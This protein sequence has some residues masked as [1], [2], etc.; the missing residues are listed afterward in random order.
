MTS[1]GNTRPGTGLVVAGSRPQRCTIWVMPS[2]FAPQP[3]LQRP[4]PPVAVLDGVLERVA[5]CNP[6]SQ[7]SEYRPSSSPDHQRLDDA[8]AQPPLHRHHPREETRRPGR[9]PPRAGRRRPHPR[10]RPPPHRPHPPPPDNRITP[11]RAR[12][13]AESREIPRFL[14]LIRAAWNHFDTPA[15]NAHGLSNG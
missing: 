6:R 10:R 12:Q 14:P 15:A 7:G 5:F 9:L 2:S 1:D 11:D 13:S 8:P 3:P 4:Q